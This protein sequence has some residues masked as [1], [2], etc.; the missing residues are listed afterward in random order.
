M[1]VEHG[2]LYCDYSFV[3]ERFGEDL[4]KRRM[5]GKTGLQYNLERVYWTFNTR[6]NNWIDQ[7]TE[8]YDC[9]LVCDL[10]EIIAAAHDILREAFFP[11]PG[12][13]DIG[14]KKRKEYQIKVL[15]EVALNLE[16]T[17]IEKIQEVINET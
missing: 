3:I 14:P 6:F 2:K 8:N 17:L 5:I 10:D 16:K 12:P 1:R 11:T 7:N 15:R 9:S 13:F 4:V